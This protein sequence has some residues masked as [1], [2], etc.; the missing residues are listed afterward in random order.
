H[1]DGGIGAG[2]RATGDQAPAA[3]QRPQRFPPTGLTDAVDHHI[4]AAIAHLQDR[5]RYAVPLVV[6]ATAGTQRDRAFDFSVARGGDEAPR[7][8]Q[9]RQLQTSD[10]D[11]PAD[12]DDQD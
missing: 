3:P 5:V 2:A 1:S 8:R 12:A 11:A 4:D 6:D 10:S 7:A 9:F